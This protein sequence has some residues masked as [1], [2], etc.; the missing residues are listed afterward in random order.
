MCSCVSLCMFAGYLGF[1]LRSSPHSSKQILYDT[2]INN[3]SFTSLFPHLAFRI[4]VP[5]HDLTIVP[6]GRTFASSVEVFENVPIKF[7][8]TS[9][10]SRPQAELTW[11]IEDEHFSKSQDQ[12][13]KTGALFDTTSTLELIPVRDYHKK[14][15]ECRSAV[16]YITNTTNIELAVFGKM[17]FRFSV[18]D[19]FTRLL[20][21]GLLP[22]WFTTVCPKPPFTLP[23]TKP[24]S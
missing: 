1:W 3:T 22:I 16:W 14:A 20:P 9:L 24:N 17:Y 4:L 19:Y 10:L 8:C 11:L 15:L 6:N 13:K 21:L 2:F 18:L 7:T 5:P 23:W 12:S